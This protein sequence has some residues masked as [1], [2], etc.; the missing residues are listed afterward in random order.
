MLFL[1]QDSIF[2][3]SLY[4]FVFVRLVEVGGRMGKDAGLAGTQ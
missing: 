1:F 2:R 3:K 4:I